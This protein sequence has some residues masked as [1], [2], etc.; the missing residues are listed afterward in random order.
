MMLRSSQGSN[1]LCW[2]AGA[3]VMVPNFSGFVRPSSQDLYDTKRMWEAG[4]GFQ[5]KVAS[6]LAEFFP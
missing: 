4:M 1:L 2:P 3:G 6:Y 5:Q